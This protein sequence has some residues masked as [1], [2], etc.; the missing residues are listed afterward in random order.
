MNNKC[1]QKFL[2]I[3]RNFMDMPEVEYT[4][5]HLKGIGFAMVVMLLERLPYRTH[6]IGL[7]SNIGAIAAKLGV[8]KRTLVNMLCRCPVFKVDLK[9]GIFYAPRLRRKYKLAATPTDEEINDV[10]HGGNI[11]VASAENAAADKR[12]S[13]NKTK[14]FSNR[15]SKSP[16]QTPGNQRKRTSKPYKDIDIS[17]RNIKVESNSA[18]AEDR[19]CHAVAAAEEFKEILSSREWRSSVTMR[20]GVNLNDD[21]VLS[22]FAAWMR[23]Y[24]VSMQKRLTDGDDVRNYAANLLRRGTR[25]RSELDAYLSECQAAGESEPERLPES[26][27]EFIFDGMRY[28]KQGQLLPLDAPAS[29]SNDLWFSYIHNC[30]VERGDYDRKAEDAVLKRRMAENIGYVRRTGGATC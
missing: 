6:T 2:R 23:S 27:F 18:C 1:S 12:G 9:R 29:T 19:P 14:T 28:T 30:W 4:I 13:E 24:C 17:N 26:P 20:T 8:Q 15:S 25:T 11:Y 16:S 5:E 22:A 21:G 10:L 3:D 7:I